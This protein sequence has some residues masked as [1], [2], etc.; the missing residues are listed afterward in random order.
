MTTKQTQTAKT[1]PK[2]RKLSKKAALARL[3]AARAIQ[4]QQRRDNL[5]KF[6]GKSW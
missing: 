5:D 3:E 1:L 2:A 4:R 6:F